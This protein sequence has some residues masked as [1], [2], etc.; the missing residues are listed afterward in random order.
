MTDYDSMNFVDFWLYKVLNNF[1]Y[2][3]KNLLNFNLFADF[4][5]T[6]FSNFHNHFS[7]FLLRRPFPMQI[8]WKQLWKRPKIIPNTA[9]YNLQFNSAFKCVQKLWQFEKRN[10]TNGVE[11]WVKKIINRKQTNNEF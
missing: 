2:Q 7:Y 6:N 8:Y 5:T 1:N 10:Q 11:M 4:S 3:K 9:I